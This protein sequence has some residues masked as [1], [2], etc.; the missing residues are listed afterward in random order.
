MAHKLTT[1][2][3]CGAG[4]GIYLETAGGQVIGAYPSMSHPTNQGRICLRGWHVHEV[5]SSPDRLQSPLLRRNGKLVEVGWAEAIHFVATR[6]KEIRSKHGPDSLAFLCSPR[7]SNEEVYLLQKLARAVIRTNNVDHGTGVYCNNSINV[8]LDMLGVAASTNSVGELAKSQVIFVDGV[9]L[10]RQLPTIG[11]IVM[12]AKLGGA[13]LVVIDSRRHR[14]AESAD[15]FLQILPGTEAVLYGAM[16]KVIV[17]AG[18]ADLAFIKGRCTGY[19][20]FVSRA[21]DCDLLSAAEYCGVAP[22]LLEAAAL[23]YGRADAAAI[24]YS[25][26]IESR[27]SEP[28]QALVNL[29]L[30]AG[31]IGREGAGIYALTEHNNL[32]GVCDVGMMPD[33]FPGYRPV[34]DES[35]R[36]DLERAWGAKLSASAG[37]PAKAILTDR[38]GGRVHAAWLCR[39]DPVSTAFFA[40]AA[41]ALAGCELV[42]T[43][44]LFLTETA[45]QADVVLP[46][47]AFGE[48]RVTFTSTDRRIQLA[49]QVLEPLPGPMPGWEQVTRVANAL[50]APW[51]YTSS[52]QVMDEIG[53]VV[54]AYSGASYA[55]L[56]ADFGRQ[57]PCTKERPL[58]TRFLFADSPPEKP[59]RFKPVPV[60]FE[61]PPPADYPLRLTFGHSAYYW[62]QNV[63]IKHSETLQRE[64]RILLLDYPA[65]FVEL[66]T[67]DARQLGVR[68]GDKIRLCAASGSAV[69]WARVTPEVR[70]G[71][72][73]LPYFLRQVQEQV[74]GPARNGQ[75]P[76]AVRVEKEAA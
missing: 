35:A 22:E 42:V 57:W 44:H 50:E 6:L 60:H 66:N 24:L 8:L 16:A 18:L 51:N 63:L 71:T 59:F 30:L 45:R 4:C 68:D 72:V 32:Q 17:D 20:E 13:K 15:I 54:P 65:G 73:F 56:A 52:G 64:Y 67:E 9:D 39:Y 37:L 11:G 25:T 43:Q 46:T 28:I 74:L 33:R 62:N 5:C 53:S 76:V 47:T 27:D 12:R 34:T 19:D 75:H 69:T 41:K 36:R 58:G 2:T 26:G 14:V 21:R 55:N 7:C 29:A 10:G 49:E 61:E 31:Q 40:D 70:R 23:A 48:E 3:F 1:C 38:A